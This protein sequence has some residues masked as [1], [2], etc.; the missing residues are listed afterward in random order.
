MVYQHVA[1]P[2]RGVVVILR[3]TIVL[4]V[5]LIRDR[6]LAIFDHTPGIV[7]LYRSIHI[8]FQ[9]SQGD[10]FVTLCGQVVHV[11][12]E[13]G[14]GRVDPTM[15]RVGNS[16]ELQYGNASKLGLLYRPHKIVEFPIRSRVAC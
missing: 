10:H 3:L 15:C 9:I 7:G 12:L 13:L 4:I 2:E 5:D 16:V 1:Q 11:L 14:F 8:L 6:S